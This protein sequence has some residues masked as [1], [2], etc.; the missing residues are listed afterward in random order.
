MGNVD[1]PTEGAFREGGTLFGGGREVFSQRVMP[2][3]R[4][5]N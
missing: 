2:A 3:F 5:Q 4:P 1:N